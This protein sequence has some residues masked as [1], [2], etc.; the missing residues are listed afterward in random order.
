[1][2]KKIEINTLG[3][4]FR[5]GK[6]MEVTTVGLGFRNGEENG[7]YHNGFRV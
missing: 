7:N 6:E 2:E 3:L 5:N 4:G 1:M